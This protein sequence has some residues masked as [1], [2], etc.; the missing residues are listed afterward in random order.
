MTTK[1][2]IKRFFFRLI[3]EPVEGK[4]YFLAANIFFMFSQFLFEAKPTTN[5]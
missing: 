1:G 2:D 4:A 5:L 3:I